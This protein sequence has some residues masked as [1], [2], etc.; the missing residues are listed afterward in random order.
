M[1]A[2]NMY[3]A[4]IIA[5]TCVGILLGISFSANARTACHTHKIVQCSEFPS[6][7]E[8][9]SSYHAIPASTRTLQ[10]T[11]RTKNAPETR[12]IDSTLQTMQPPARI[13]KRELV[14]TNITDS[15]TAATKSEKQPCDSNSAS[16]SLSHTTATKYLL[17]HLVSSEEQ[18]QWGPMQDDEML[19][20]YSFIRVTR[21]ARILELGG[22]RGDSA[23]N[24]LQ[25]TEGLVDST[26]FTVD[27]QM[28]PKLHSRHVP[29]QKDARLLTAADVHNRPLDLVLL[30]C[31]HYDATMGT[32]QAL[33]RAFLI[34]NATLA[35]HDTGLHGN[36]MHQI[37]ER[38]V[39]N[40]LID[41]GIKGD[42]SDTWFAI[43]AH[44]DHIARG[45]PLAY[46]HGITLM[47]RARRL[48]NKVDKPQGGEGVG[49]GGPTGQK[50]GLFQGA[51]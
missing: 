36:K 19:F 23:R 34:E 17:G 26:V 31:H 8:Q 41:R 22:L 7:E 20:L 16:T 50:D 33:D 48:N 5:C 10:R 32:L 30:D 21:A 40:E 3:L 43:H 11:S 46:R 35:L 29:L 1:A 2:R 27:L 9:P 47:Q 24:F 4:T 44:R 49:T 12:N 13:I 25:A 39:V 18:R 28:V 45:D 37:V 15:I 51:D 14:E 42:R 38:I 6:T